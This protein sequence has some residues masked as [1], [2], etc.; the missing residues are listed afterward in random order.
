MDKIALLLGI[1]GLSYGLY[2]FDKNKK[3]SVGV[4]VFSVLMISSSMVSL[5]PTF[6]GEEKTLMTIVK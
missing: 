1:G 2:T 3:V 6:Q 4:S 5:M